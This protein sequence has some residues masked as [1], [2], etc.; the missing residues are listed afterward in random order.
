VFIRKRTTKAGSIS[1]ALVE[2]YRDH[3][4]RP[5]HRILPNLHGESDVLSA[6]AKLTVLRTAL[7]GE[8]ALML[9]E[10]E[11]ISGVDEKRQL[12][13]RLLPRFQ[14]IEAIIPRIEREEAAIRKYCSASDEEFEAACEAFQERISHAVNVCLNDALWSTEANANFRRLNDLSFKRGQ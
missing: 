6:L 8:Q 3:N 9:E 12:A 11:E 2:A 1:T 5:R 14:Q 7:R 13:R 4:G 10:V